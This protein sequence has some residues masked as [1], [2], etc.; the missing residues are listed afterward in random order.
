M[1]GADQAVVDD[2]ALAQ[3]GAQV[4]AGAIDR[5]QAAVAVPIDGDAAPEP[6]GRQDLAATEVSRTPCHV[7]GFDQQIGVGKC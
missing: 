3:V 6:L 1:E 7:P 2:P 5:V 4:G